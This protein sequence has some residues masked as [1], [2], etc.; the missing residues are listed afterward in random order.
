MMTMRDLKSQRQGHGWGQVEAAGRMGVSQPYL[1][2]LESGKRR[3]TPA[4]VRKAVAAYGLPPAELPLPV[5]FAPT[6]KVD[7]KRLVQDLAK[8]DYPG[9]AYVRSRVGSKSSGEV[10][11]T[12]LAQESLE[13]RAAEALPW[14]LLRYW[15]MDLSWLVGEAKKFDLQN[16][17]GFVVNLARQLSERGPETGRTQALASL[18]SL[19]ECSRL[20]REDYFYRA[21]RNDRERQ[22]L[23]QNR[24]DA[25][26]H[27]N[28][29]SDL[30]LEH[31]QY[32]G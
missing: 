27:W 4:L 17:L 15:H 12:A 26:R 25:A 5:A 14:L 29:L 16:R 7:G 24:P 13:G 11:L 20:A 18:E 21:P 19:L 9:F 8:L 22:W 2:L 6:R 30:R 23:A 28:L 32:A 31:L 3:L 1:A 10:L